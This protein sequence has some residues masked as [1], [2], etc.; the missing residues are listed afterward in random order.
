[1]T[2][3]FSELETNQ[4]KERRQAVKKKNLCGENDPKT[5]FATARD[6]SDDLE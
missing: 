1:M 4:R 2:L 6:L 3:G 5:S